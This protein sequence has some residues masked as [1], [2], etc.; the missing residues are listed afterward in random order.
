MEFRIYERTRTAADPV[1][2]DL[3]W[4]R[5]AAYSLARERMGRIGEM[6]RREAEM[7]TGQP[8]LLV[9]G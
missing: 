3:A 6:A 7:L 1:D 4:A 9:G 8:P 2:A 5:E